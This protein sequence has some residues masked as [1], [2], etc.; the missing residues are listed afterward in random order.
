MKM[1]R[2]ALLGCLLLLLTCAHAQQS[3]AFLTVQ[4][5]SLIHI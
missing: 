1:R 3:P 5:L 4:E 2:T